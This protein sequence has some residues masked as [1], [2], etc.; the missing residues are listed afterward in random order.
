MGTGY[1]QTWAAAQETHEHGGELN[2]GLEHAWCCSL[3]CGVHMFWGSHR[4]GADSSQTG[5]RVCAWSHHGTK[6]GAD[7]RRSRQ[8]DAQE[9]KEPF[10]SLIEQ[11]FTE[12]YC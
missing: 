5:Q 8:S 12:H 6:G 4:D 2:V 10:I 3:T 1:L 7:N 9:G 11:M